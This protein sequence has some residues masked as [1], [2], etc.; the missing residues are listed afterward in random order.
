MESSWDTEIQIWPKS[1]NS[2]PKNWDYTMGA[3]LLYLDGSLKLL[4]WVWSRNAKISPAKIVEK[5]KN[6]MPNA[7]FN[8]DELNRK[9]V[10]LNVIEIKCEIIDGRFS[11]DQGPLLDSCKTTAGLFAEKILPS[12]LNDYC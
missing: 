2:K 12:F 3:S 10:H 6:I 8:I 1:L 4:I 9:S 7:V 11:V 5:Y